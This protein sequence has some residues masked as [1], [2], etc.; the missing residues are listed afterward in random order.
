LELISK[1][2]YKVEFD[3]IK[4]L[5]LRGNLE[6]I[7]QEL[8]KDENFNKFFDMLQDQLG[9][10]NLEDKNSKKYQLNDVFFCNT[11]QGIASHSLHRIA[12]H[13][14]FDFLDHCCDDTSPITKYEC[15]LTMICPCLGIP[16]LLCK[17]F[18][19]MCDECCDEFHHDSTNGARISM[20]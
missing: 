12:D 19:N 20:W 9:T 10:I 11:L 6:K 16:Y 18:C 8:S 4:L 17:G 13:S 1:N 2:A 3:I 14:F 7:S 5:S 15:V